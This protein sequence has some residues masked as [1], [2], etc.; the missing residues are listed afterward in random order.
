MGLLEFMIESNRI[1]GIYREPTHGEVLCAQY[2]LDLQDFVL[3]DVIVLQASIAPGKL[4]RDQPGMNVR[5]ADHI[6]PA[7]GPAIITQLENLLLTIQIPGSDPWMCHCAFEELHPFMDGNGRTGR[8]LWV[9]MMLRN[10]QN[11]YALPFLHRWYYQTLS[12]TR[13]AKPIYTQPL[14]APD[15]R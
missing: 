5:A 7:G 15:A 9:W 3:S 1:E 13:I 10:K 11:P 6:A 12:S 4:L 14:E 8:M 2:F